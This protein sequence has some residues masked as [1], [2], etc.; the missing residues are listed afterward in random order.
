MCGNKKYDNSIIDNLIV[1]HYKSI[2]KGNKKDFYNLFYTDVCVL[3]PNSFPITG[4]N[5]L[6][7]YTKSWFDNTRTYEILNMETEV[8]SKIAY[9][10]VHYLSTTYAWEREFQDDMKDFYILKMNKDN[11]W[12]SK[13][14]MWSSN[15]KE[16]SL[17]NIEKVYTF[18]DKINE[19]IKKQ[20]MIEITNSKTSQEVEEVRKD[21][22][23]CAI[24]VIEDAFNEKFIDI[25]P[26]PNFSTDRKPDLK[27]A[28]SFTDFSNFFGCNKLWIEY[29]LTNETDFD[30][31]RHLKDFLSNDWKIIIFSENKKPEFIDIEEL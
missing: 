15:L 23:N 1:E 25:L 20:Y 31:R 2:E 6:K 22:H 27:I 28:S 19:E 4:I 30:K 5:N 3:P 10:Y 13:Y 8:D 12:K 16:P 26:D 9:I 24:N 21:K 18:L 17:K 11:E 14:Y 29:D 7:E